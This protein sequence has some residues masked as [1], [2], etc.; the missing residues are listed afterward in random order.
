MTMG[1]AYVYVYVCGIVVLY[2][3]CGWIYVCLHTIDGEGE[4]HRISDATY[5]LYCTIEVN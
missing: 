4:L 5:V 1:V 3:V 2:V